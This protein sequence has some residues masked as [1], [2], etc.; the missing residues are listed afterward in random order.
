MYRGKKTLTSTPLP[1]NNKKKEKK[2]QG[3]PA[4]LKQGNKY[5]KIIPLAYLNS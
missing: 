5:N 1:F 3:T 4:P 2:N